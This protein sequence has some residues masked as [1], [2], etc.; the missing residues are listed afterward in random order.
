MALK[1]G[2]TLQLD[3]LN[4]STFWDTDP[5]LL[6][7]VKDRDFIIVRVLE[8]GTDVEIRHIES[9]FSQ[10]TII[11]ALEKSKEVSRKTLNFYKTIS[12]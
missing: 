10:Q 2:K 9:V 11:S 3:I 8:R 1:K 12:I 5:K 6:D 7:L 4:P